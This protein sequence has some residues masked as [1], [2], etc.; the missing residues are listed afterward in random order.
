[1]E[2]PISDAFF[3]CVCMIKPDVL[4]N[5]ITCLCYCSNRAGGPT[6]SLYSSPVEP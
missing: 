2:I 5:Q 4:I 1:M 6:W 3:N